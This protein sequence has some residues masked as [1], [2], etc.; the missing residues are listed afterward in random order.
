[1]AQTIFI[2]GSSSGIGK[3][4]ARLFQERGWNVVA[5]MRSPERETE[6]TQLDNVL[7]TR[8]DVLD[9]AS[10]ESAVAQGVKRFGRIDVLLNNAG[11]GAYGP[12]E[13]FTADRIRRQFE[14]NVLG[15]LAV[16]QALLP[17]FRRQHA[18]TVINISSMGGKVA[19]P[20][21][22]LYHG[23]KYAVEGISEALSFEL[24]AIGGRIKIIEPGLI[25]TD[26]DG[27]SIDF[28]NDETLE[29]Y[30]PLIGTLVQFQ[31]AGYANA[32]P[33]TEVAA[34]VYEAATDGSARMRYTAGDDARQLLEARRALDDEAFL[35]TIK[36]QFGM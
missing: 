29:E 24:E 7:V 17:Y 28:A 8:L 9:P 20:L 36:A 3:A 25:R 6:L 32:A 18:G 22:A 1:M 33:A 10:I 13:A 16:T 23:T 27:R 21:G 34:V 35:G 11:Y 26:F 4:T 2:T 15:V 30:Q 5:S 19:F 12:L 14:V 31:Q